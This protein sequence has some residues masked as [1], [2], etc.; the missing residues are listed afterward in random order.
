MNDDVKE[1]VE[2]VLSRERMALGELDDDHI[3]PLG[4]TSQLHNALREAQ[5]MIGAFT[6][7]DLAGRLQLKL[8]GLHERSN[9]LIAAGVLTREDDLQPSAA[10]GARTGPASGRRQGRVPPGHWP[11]LA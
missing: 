7:P 9:Q 4:G 3:E 11:V 5:K 6:A 10:S 2:L 8:P 1:S